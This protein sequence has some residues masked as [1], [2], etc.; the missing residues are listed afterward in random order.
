M[1]RAAAKEPAFAPSGALNAG[2]EP[3][4]S[5][6]LRAGRLRF[7][8]GD[9]PALIVEAARADQGKAGVAWSGP[10]PSAG[11]RPGGV[12]RLTATPKPCQYGPTGMT[13][14]VTAVIEVAGHRYSGCAA[15]PGQGLGP[16]S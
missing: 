10:L 1:R 4:W 2:G 14:P 7:V 3:G 16:R 13:Y 11:G 15:Q 9:A 5:A 12:L 8:S 6:Q